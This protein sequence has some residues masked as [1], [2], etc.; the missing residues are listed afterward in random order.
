MADAKNGTILK[1]YTN[2]ENKL[3]S[4]KWMRRVDEKNMKNSQKKNIGN[5]Q[6]YGAEISSMAHVVRN[7]SSI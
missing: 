3:I 1:N 7:G 6:E 5:K 2:N 4:L